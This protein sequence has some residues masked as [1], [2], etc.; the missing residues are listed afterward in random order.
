M[1]R[2]GMIQIDVEELLD[3]VDDE[4]LIVEVQS[5]KLIVGSPAT[6]FV[7]ED[8]IREA[9]AELLRGRPREAMAILDRMINPKWTD[10]KAAGIALSTRMLEKQP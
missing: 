5:R 4:N 9:Y 6:D 10:A 3:Q 8:D 7:P 1:R 2:S